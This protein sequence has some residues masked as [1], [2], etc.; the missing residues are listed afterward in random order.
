MYHPKDKEQKSLVCVYCDKEG[1]KSSDCQTISQIFYM[2]I[3][4]FQ[5]KLCFNYTSSKHRAAD[6]RSIKESLNFKEK[7][8]FSSCKNHSDNSMLLTRSSNSA[9]HPVIVI[10]VEDIKWRALIDNGVVV[11]VPCQV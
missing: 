4:L 10:E 3:I 6:C 5:R 9:T 7:H 11:H 2:K 8:H 1:H